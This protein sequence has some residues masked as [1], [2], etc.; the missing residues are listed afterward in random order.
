MRPGDVLEGPEGETATVA[1]APEP[2]SEA[3]A[4]SPVQLAAAAYH[5]GNRH[6][7][8]ELGHLRVRFLRDPVLEDLVGGMGL[9][10][11]RLS[12]PFDPE[13]GA[14]GGHGG[15]R[16]AAAEEDCHGRVGARE[17]DSSR[18]SCR[19]PVR[20]CGSVPASGAGEEEAAGGARASGRSGN[21]PPAG[22]LMRLLYAASPLRP[23]G[24]FAWSGG[25]SQYVLSGGV[26]D[27]GGLKA[28]IGDA[29]RLVLVPCDLPLLARCFAAAVRRDA[30]AFAR[31][32]AVSLASRGTRELLMGERETGASVMRMLEAGGL[33]DGFPDGMREGRVGYVAAYGLMA[34]ALGLSGEDAGRVAGAFLWGAVENLALCAAKS[35]PLGQGAVQ[36][37]LLELLDGLLPQAA[38]EAMLLDDWELGACAPL[39]AI[40]SSEHESSPLRMFRS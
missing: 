15:G 9:A 28:W 26:S 29:V 30:G 17:H 5:L 37:V 19:A 34:A 8:V 22:A 25:L 2:L 6:A 3:R 20:S 36:G 24:S 31:W 12:A 32:N 21:L 14:Y 11:A 18:D 1:A 7:E 38:E 4:V 13:G 35:V 27:A 33:L 40:R 16:H 23:T 39:L 10:V